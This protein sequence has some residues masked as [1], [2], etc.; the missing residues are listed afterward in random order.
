MSIIDDGKIWLRGSA[1][2]EY[3]VRV[4]KGYFITGKEDAEIINYLIDDNFLYVDILYYPLSSY[5]HN[6]YKG[7]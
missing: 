3:G 1:R 4:G 5:I 2:P 6:L 7:W